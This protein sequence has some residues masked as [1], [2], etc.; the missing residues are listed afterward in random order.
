[1]RSRASARPEQLQLAGNSHPDL[2]TFRGA[3]PERDSCALYL[4]YRR[5]PDGFCCPKCGNKNVPYRFPNRSSVVL[6]CRHC[7]SNIS[8]TTGTVAQKSRLPLLLWLWAAYLV[9]LGIKTRSAK[10]LQ[11]EFRLSRYESALLA[12]RKVRTQGKLPNYWSHD[13]LTRL[14]L[15]LGICHYAD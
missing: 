4:E 11:R 5:W 3:F 1:M 13:F 12:W 2:N 9:A 6:R 10:D 8:L 14:D 7:K 15:A